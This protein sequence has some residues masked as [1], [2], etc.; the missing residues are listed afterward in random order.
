MLLENWKQTC[1]ENPQ[2]VVFAEANHD[3]VIRAARFLFDEGLANPVL[4]GGGFELRDLADKLKVNT[5][6]LKIV[7]PN[8]AQETDGFLPHILKQNKNLKR[9]EAANLIKDPVIQSIFRL[10]GG[11]ADL[12]FAGNNSSVANVV[13]K[14][15]KWSGVHNAFRRV[16]SFYVMISPDTKNVLAF[17]DCSVNVFPNPR[18]LA[19]IALK[20]ALNYKLVT[21]RQPRIVFLSFS[22]K[23][24]AAHKKLKI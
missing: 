19:E 15:L 9:L 8:H 6:G 22:T 5:R 21:G 3:S 12:A 17:A 14:G 20:T 10:K 11:R 16:S 24:S 2:T 18:E 4:L 1:R 13:S 7:N 23:G